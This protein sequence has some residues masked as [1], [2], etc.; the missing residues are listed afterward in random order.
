MFK[1][2]RTNKICTGFA[3]STE[4]KNISLIIKV[5]DIYVERHVFSLDFYPSLIQHLKNDA[6]P[7]IYIDSNVVIIRPCAN[8][9]KLMVLT[10]FHQLHIPWTKKR[11]HPNIQIQV[12]ENIL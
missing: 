2:V 10:A 3:Y 9:K 11:S 4:L 8:V 6:N 5:T 7:V 12:T 1:A